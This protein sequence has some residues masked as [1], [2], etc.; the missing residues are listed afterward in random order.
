M[1][2]IKHTSLFKWPQ[3]GN[4][5]ALDTKS[6]KQ[7]AQKLWIHP[8][9]TLQNGHIAYLVKVNSLHSIALFSLSIDTDSFVF[10][11]RSTLAMSK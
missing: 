7:Q 11:P 2:M 5:K 1:K 3:N 4:A 9:A 6:T 8:P 10:V